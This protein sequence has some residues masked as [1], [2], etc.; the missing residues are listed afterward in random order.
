MILTS[1]S[2]F[3]QNWQPKKI[4]LKGESGLFLPFSIMDSLTVKLIDRKG[5]KI[6]TERLNLLTELNEKT[7][8]ELKVKIDL[9]EDKTNKFKDIIQIQESQKEEALR[10]LE[11]QKSISTVYKKKARKN[12]IF[13]IGSG[14][15]LG[16]FAVLALN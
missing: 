14:F 3:S 7:L 16:F 8:Q 13:G 5:L 6:E 4:K 2:A 12:A 11:T 10:L 1:A 9:L 15:V